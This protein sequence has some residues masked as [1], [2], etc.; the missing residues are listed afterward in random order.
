M[1]SQESQLPGAG[2]SPL[3]ESTLDKDDEYTDSTEMFF[4]D[5]ETLPEI[6]MNE[7]VSEMP[8]K[9]LASHGGKES[10]QM[11]SP[12]SETVVS[13]EEL[14]A[15]GLKQKEKV[16]YHKLNSFRPDFPH[17]PRY[18]IVTQFGCSIM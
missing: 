8:L 17:C 5:K 4:I 2:H 18:L 14:P 12:R 10:A 9:T 6:P 7:A 15:L 16:C 11:A 13:P 1:L 3:Q